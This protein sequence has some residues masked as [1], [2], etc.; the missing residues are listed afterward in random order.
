MYAVIATGGKQY[1]V[2][3]GDIIRVER[4]DGEQG[5][6]IEFGGVLLV[7]DG[8]NVTVGTPY[9]EGTKVTGT[10]RAQARAK[11]IEVIKCKRRKNYRRQMGHRQAYTE[12]EITSIAG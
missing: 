10:I 4:L 11:K 7:S 8:E 12:V 2:S 9:V 5:A 3:Q 6:T 1:K